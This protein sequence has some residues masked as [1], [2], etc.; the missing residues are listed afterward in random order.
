MHTELIEVMRN[1]ASAIYWAVTGSDV[2]QSEHGESASQ[3]APGAA[4]TTEADA[5]SID[6]VARKFVEL[7]VMARSVPAVA[8]HVPPFSFVPALDVIEE[9]DG[10]LI[11]ATVPG[12]DLGDVVVQRAG[13]MLSIAGNRRGPLPRCKYQHAEIP[14]GPFFRELRLP[15]PVEGEPHVELERGLLKVRFKR[16][17]AGQDVETVTGA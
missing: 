5:A 7:E 10:L 14:R 4:A 6:E 16:A 17:P 12:V 8:E 15:F 11:E 9:D 3:P 2:P 13:D 1:Q